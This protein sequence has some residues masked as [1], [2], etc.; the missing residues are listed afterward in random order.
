MLGH[1]LPL[2]YDSSGSRKF[3]LTT[4]WPEKEKAYMAI[5]APHRVI[6]PVPREAHECSGFIVIT[7]EDIQKFRNVGA[8]R[9]SVYCAG[10]KTS[11]TNRSAVA[12]DTLPNPALSR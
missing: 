6:D 11:T 3:R 4:L 2:S 8:D 5:R 9:L 10:A 7:I 12:F 1:I